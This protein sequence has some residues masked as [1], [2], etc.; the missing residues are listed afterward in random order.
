MLVSSATIREIGLMDESYFLYW[1]DTEWCARALA[2]GY[3]VF[4]V[5]ASLVWHKVS[6]STGH[7]SFQ[8]LYYS[9]RNGFRFLWGHDKLLLPVFAVFNFLYGIK[10]LMTGNAQPLQGLACG[11]LDFILGKNGPRRPRSALA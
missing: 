10:A 9:T 2:N 3:K 5:P 7:G 6:V 11:F 4:L 8:Q 1:E